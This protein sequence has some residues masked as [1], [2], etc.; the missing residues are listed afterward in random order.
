MIAPMLAVP[1]DKAS[2]TDWRDWVIEQKFDGHRLI[3]HVAAHSVKAW[4]RPRKHAG[5]GSAKTMAERPL[6]AHLVDAF[7]ALPEGI[8]DGELLA[9]ETSTDVTRVDLQNT[10]RF[11][12]FDVIQIGMAV[13]QT[14]TYDER[15]RELENLFGPKRRR[16]SKYVTLAESKPLTC[17]DDV[18]AFVQGVWLGQGE[19]AILKRRASLYRPGKR[20]PDWIKVK[21]L[22]TTVCTV[23]GFK[24]TK[25]TVLNRGP[26]ACVILEDAQG[27]RTSVKTKDDAELARFTTQWSVSTKN[28]LPY[29]LGD[30]HP[31]IGRQLRIEYQDFTPKDG[32]RHPRWD[33]WEDE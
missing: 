9:G 12:V 8:Y 3:V 4:T 2:V 18:T 7:L 33:R 30:S 6:P 22:L 27:N 25:G 15:R 29:K 31:A 32:Y 11:V 21:K 23:V 26:F 1:M 17:L 13:L 14:C 16:I 28:G 20:S 24:P 19:G 10:L 5:S